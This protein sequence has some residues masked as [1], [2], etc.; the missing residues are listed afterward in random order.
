VRL[1]RAVLCRDDIV[2]CNGAAAMA[3][4][5]DM[6]TTLAGSGLGASPSAAGLAVVP[7]LTAQSAVLVR[8]WA[9]LTSRSQAG[10]ASAGAVD[11]LSR[12]AVS[13]V[14]EE[15][16]HV[17]LRFLAAVHT[18]LVRAGSEPRDVRCALRCLSKV[19]R[20]H[21]ILSA[22][23][24]VASGATLACLSAAAGVALLGSQPACEAEAAVFLRDEALRD[25]AM[26]SFLGE[27]VVPP[28]AAATAGVAAGSPQA[29]AATRAIGSVLLDP[30]GGSQN[31]VERILAAVG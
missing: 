4:M 20:A 16:S 23:A 1:L 26:A 19:Q 17:A 2:R 31:L 24:V 27:H 11:V 15:A 21:R 3:L 25:A 7:V 29:A 22:P 14:S 30:A 12:R 18:T 8:H 28:V 5:T 10:G 6:T 9:S 13:F